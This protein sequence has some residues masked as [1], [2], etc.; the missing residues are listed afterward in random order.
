MQ[1]T[2]PSLCW[3]PSGAS[4]IACAGIWDIT[5]LGRVSIGVGDEW[6][7]EALMHLFPSCSRCLCLGLS[8]SRRWVHLDPLSRSQQ[9]DSSNYKI[10]LKK[11][12]NINILS[13]PRQNPGF[14]SLQN[15]PHI[16]GDIVILPR[17]GL[18]TLMLLGWTRM[19]SVRVRNGDLYIQNE[20]FFVSKLTL[21]RK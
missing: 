4:W 21:L 5:T 11:S 3:L 13:L 7:A 8:T 17:P 10:N 6:R 1:K 18:K 9:C 2:P 15:V 16:C 14:H 19:V 20:Q 12:G